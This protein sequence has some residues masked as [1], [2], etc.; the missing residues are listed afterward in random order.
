MPDEL[1]CD[2]PWYLDSRQI[3][4]WQ[5]HSITLCAGEKCHVTAH[6]V[7]V[8]VTGMDLVTHDFVLNLDARERHQLSSTSMAIKCEARTGRH[9]TI[10]RRV[11]VRG[12]QRRVHAL[13]TIRMG[14]PP[15]WS[16]IGVTSTRRAARLGGSSFRPGQTR[17]KRFRLRRSGPSTSSSIDLSLSSTIKFKTREHGRA[18]GLV[19]Y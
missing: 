4:R 15:M 14:R 5:R 3:R 19:C 6:S 13:K 7:E 16:A 10:S 1:N 8:P 17:V 2:I 9:M 11:T 18:P 12:T